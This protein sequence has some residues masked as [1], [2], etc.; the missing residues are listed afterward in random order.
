MSKA[1]RGCIRALVLCAVALI[2]SLPAPA[3]EEGLSPIELPAYVPTGQRGQLVITPEVAARL[4]LDRNLK[5]EEAAEGIREAQGRL[6]QARAGGRLQATLTALIARLGPVSTLSMP[7]TL[8]GGTFQTGTDHMENVTIRLVQPLYTGGR[9][10]LAYH[11]ASQGVSAAELSEAS[12]R[13]ALLLGSQEAIYA[14]LRLEQLAGVAAARVTAVAEHARLSQLMEDAGVVAHFEVVQ[15]QSEL[16]R[17]QRDLITAQTALAQAK[18]NLRNLLNLP[19]TIDLDVSDG[20]SPA[21]PTGDLPALIEQAT[22]AR[23]EVKLADT[24][25]TIAEMNLRLAHAAMRPTVA[26]VSSYTQQTESAFQGEYSWQVGLSVEKPLLDGGQSD[27]RVREA[28]AALRAARV[29][30]A[31][32]R[33]DIAL[34][35]A[36]QMLAVAEAREKIT[37]AQQGIVEARE[38][39]RMAQLRYREGITAGIEVLDADTALAAA[40]ADLVNSEYD[41]KLA[42]V[43]LQAALGALDVPQQEVD[44]P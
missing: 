30:Q 39:R 29:R 36:V 20:A 28:E 12:V 32:A 26:L 42:I 15:A 22:A 35:V 44:T 8:G 10:E 38:R 1:T 9:T 5:L 33:E 41:L 23:P 31:Q 16:A 6:Q 13:R 7:E 43:R 25:A 19:Q 18:A 34:E 17:A 21:E 40:E 2:L 11:I 37:A 14:V 4:V 24:A 27:G 3:Q